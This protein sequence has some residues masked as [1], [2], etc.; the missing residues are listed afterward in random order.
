MEPANNCCHILDMKSGMRDSHGLP[1]ARESLKSRHGIDA[2]GTIGILII[3][4]LLIPSLVAADGMGFMYRYA[5]PH[6]K[7]SSLEPMAVD[8]QRAVIAHKNGVQRMFIAINLKNPPSSKDSSRAGVWIFP[9]LGTPD[10]A[11]VEVTSFIPELKGRD[12]EQAA[13]RAMHDA[14][15]C[16]T[17]SQPHFFAFRWGGRWAMF[18]GMSRIYMGLGGMTGRAREVEGVTTYKRVDRWGIHAEIITADSVDR[19]ADYLRHHGVTVDTK[20][21]HPFADYLSEEYVLVVAWISS[22][23]ALM[24]RFPQHRGKKITGQPT[25]YVEFPTDRPFFPMKPTSGYGKNTMRVSLYLLGFQKLSTP[26]RMTA[27]QRAIAPRMRFFAGGRKAF[28]RGYRSFVERLQK[29]SETRSDKKESEEMRKAVDRFLEAVPEGQILF[30]KASI[31][32]PAEKFT[33]DLRFTR[34]WG[35]SILHAV[36]SSTPVMA[37]VTLLL[38]VGLSYVSGGMSGRLVYGTWKPWARKGLWNCL[39]IV[40]L[41]ISAWWSRKTINDEETHGVSSGRWE[42]LVLSVLL[43]LSLFMMLKTILSVF[44]GLSSRDPGAW[45]TETAWIVLGVLSLIVAVLGAWLASRGGSNRPEEAHENPDGACGPIL[46]RPRE[47]SIHIFLMVAAAFALFWIIPSFLTLNATDISARGSNAGAEILVSFLLRVG[48]FCVAAALITFG[49]HVSARFVRR[50][51]TF[52]SDR[53][54]PEKGST[55]DRMYSKRPEVMTLFLLTAIPVT[56]LIVSI[57]F[58]SS[59][60]LLDRH[61]MVVWIGLISV[62]MIVATWIVRKGSQAKLELDDQFSPARPIVVAVILALPSLCV[63][64]ASFVTYLMPGLVMILWRYPSLFLFPASGI[65]AIAMVPILI[66]GFLERKRLRRILGRMTYRTAL[67]IMVAILGLL[68][69][70]ST[71]TILSMGIQAYFVRDFHAMMLFLWASATVCFVGAWVVKGVLKEPPSKAL[72]FGIVFSIVFGL[73]CCVTLIVVKLP[74]A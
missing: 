7:A 3:L 64:L 68:T 65:V 10:R 5:S 15:W 14:L 11:D 52:F 35:V 32:A 70:C 57:P 43:S 40:A 30:T 27:E 74:L 72:R 25:L 46:G 37:F 38:L 17:A 60:R 23:D 6:R 20:Q 1:S 58:L 13:K 4:F 28:D 36:T 2:S 12:V 24:K 66:I 39:S 50:S 48:L 63:C 49:F 33:M 62:E 51:G 71:V 41:V 69:Y 42:A 19:L 9:V 26:S 21:L 18:S 8:E 34:S 29:D 67:S 22:Y 54:N 59:T 56:L 16:L 44:E 61:P 45:Q 53:R 31:E 47:S 55:S 73:L